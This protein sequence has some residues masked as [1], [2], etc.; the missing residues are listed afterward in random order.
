MQQQGELFKRCLPAAI[1]AV[2]DFGPGRAARLLLRQALRRRYIRPSPPGLRIAVPFDLDHHDPLRWQSGNLPEP[3]AVVINRDN[4]RS[5]LVYLLEVPVRLHD[6]ERTRPMRLL[7]AVE[8]CYATRL[9][10]DLAYA[11]TFVK[12]PYS[13]VFCGALL[14]A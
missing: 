9:R 8:A 4:G 1:K 5:H 11:G 10:A 7:E 14:V 12:N 6:A 3:H 13:S 2:D